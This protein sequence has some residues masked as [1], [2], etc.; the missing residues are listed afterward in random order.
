M[1]LS[2]IKAEQFT[3][4]MLLRELANFQN[5]IAIGE[6]LILSLHKSVVHY[7]HMENQKIPYGP[8]YNL[9]FI[10]LRILYEYLN[11][12]LVKG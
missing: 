11:D 12:A 2:P 7:I 3:Q 6:K 8:L 4:I 9:S 1:L 5:V 10:E